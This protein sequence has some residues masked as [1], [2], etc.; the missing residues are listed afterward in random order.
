MA[1]ADLAGKVAIVTGGGSGLGREIVLEYAARGAEVVVA[2]NA[3]DENEAVAAEAGTGA[4]A[5][6]IDVRDEGHVRSLVARTLDELGRV[7]VLVT[8][9]GIDVRESPRREDRHVRNVSL[10]TWET[11]LAVNLTGTFLS[12]REVLPHMLERRTG[13]IV[14]FT[15][16]TVRSP[17]PG[18]AAYASSKA[19]IEALTEVV[20][21]EVAPHGVRANVLQPGGPTRTA[22]FGDSIP[23]DEQARFHDPAVIRDCAAHLASDASIGVT[24]RSF[25]AAEWNR[26]HGLRLCS[27]AA[28]AV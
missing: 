27:C 18:L 4:L 23:E 5:I 12:I 13:S 21:L 11:V 8:A 28:C 2:S 26:E 7:D 24:G 17:R 15:S 16:G 19:A 25:V 9:A 1:V 20:A 22:F 3:P 14:T 10:A 6:A